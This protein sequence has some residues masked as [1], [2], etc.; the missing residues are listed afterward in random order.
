MSDRKF[1][2]HLDTTASASVTVDFTADEVAEVE[3]EVREIYNTEDGRND[4]DGIARAVTERLLEMASERA[5][6]VG[7]PGLCA[8]C[9]GWG[10][11]RRSMDI[12]GEWEPPQVYDPGTGRHREAHYDEYVDE[13]S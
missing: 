10:D 1:R 3:A 8:Q 12:A 7:T 5:Y 4:A 13:V 6:E 11:P 2:V 9:S